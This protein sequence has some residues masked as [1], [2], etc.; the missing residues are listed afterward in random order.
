[1]RFLPKEPE[2]TA[3]LNAKYPYFLDSWIPVGW[4]PQATEPIKVIG[5]ETVILVHRDFPEYAAYDILEAL[6]NNKPE[7]EAIHATWVAVTDQ[8]A[9]RNMPVPL[10]PGSER[11]FTSR[12]FAISYLE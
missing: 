5:C 12:G 8:T 6:F 2:I 3:S 10:H 7:L 1:M 4:T 11:F 9:A